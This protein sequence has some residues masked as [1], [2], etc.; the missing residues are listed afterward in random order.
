[1]ANNEDQRSL[2]ILSKQLAYLR[3]NP[4]QH[5]K[6]DNLIDTKFTVSKKFAYDGYIFCKFLYAKENQSRFN[7]DLIKEKTFADANE[8]CFFVCP[9]DFTPDV[10]EDIIAEWDIVFYMPCGICLCWLTNYT[11]GA[12][13]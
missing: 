7:R 11:T 13:Y 12:R 10:G 6:S 5:Q 3:E 9:K 1:M 2:D 8:S 4:M